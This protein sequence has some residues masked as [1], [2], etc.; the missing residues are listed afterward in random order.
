[1][2]GLRHHGINESYIETIKKTDFIPARTPEKFFTFPEPSEEVKAKKFTL[3]D[4]K[5]MDA[6][7]ERH[8]IM[9][10]NG[11]V[12][13]VAP[14][15]EQLKKYMQ[16]NFGM[17]MTFFLLLIFLVLGGK[18][19]TYLMVKSLYDPTLPKVKKPEDV[20]ELHERWAENQMGVFQGNSF[21]LSCCVNFFF[22]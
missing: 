5:N 1:V 13:R 20:T 14:P 9:G 6:A 15:D 22:L 12:L 19:V 10:V 8:I 7:D 21:Y 18:D 17:S 4:V 3:E 16:T 2:L 11:K